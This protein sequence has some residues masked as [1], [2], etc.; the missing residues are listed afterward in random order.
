[1]ILHEFYNCTDDGLPQT[2]K[3]A[4][5]REIRR[6]QIEDEMARA[7]E[8]AAL[9]AASPARPLLDLR[10]LR[11]ACVEVALACLIAAPVAC[12]YVCCLMLAWA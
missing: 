8:A 1:M 4:L 3:Q 9:A 6:R 2:Y 10:E 11:A 12:G 5:R 7:A